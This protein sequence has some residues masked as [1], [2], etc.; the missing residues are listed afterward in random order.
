MACNGMNLGRT[1]CGGCCGG[2]WTPGGSSCTWTL[3][4]IAVIL[5]WINCGC[6]FGSGGCPT[7]CVS[8]C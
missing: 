8:D 3:I 6:S 1:S 5:V 4:I 2:G 7:P